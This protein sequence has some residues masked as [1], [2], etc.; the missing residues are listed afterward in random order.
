MLSIERRANQ[1]LSTTA[2]LPLLLGEDTPEEAYIK[3]P[4][5]DEVTY[6]QSIADF[7]INNLPSAGHGLSKSRFITDYMQYHSPIIM[8][9]YD[10]LMRQWLLEKDSTTQHDRGIKIGEMSAVEVLKLM[11]NRG[12]PTFYLFHKTAHLLTPMNSFTRV[13]GNPFTR[14]NVDVT[15]LFGWTTTYVR[16][17]DQL[18]YVIG[19]PMSELLEGQARIDTYSSR[20][21]INFEY[22]S[23]GFLGVDLARMPQKN[24]QA[25][26][27]KVKIFSTETSG[28]IK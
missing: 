15:T 3:L 17:G 7:I 16:E 27:A 8:P 9:F 22:L 5:F 18:P 10:P 1:L 25:I 21:E 4:T 11:R 20:G 28:L 2:L 6:V 14:N 13:H 24:I 26:L 19:F 12:C 23:R